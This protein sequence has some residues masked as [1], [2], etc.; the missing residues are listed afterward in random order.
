MA[1][2]AKTYDLIIIGAG[3]AGLGA[4]VYA[5]REGMTTLILEKGVVGGMAAI[6]DNIDNYPGFENGVGGLELADHLYD[7]AKRFGADIQ[8]GVEVTGLSRQD[9]NV[10]VST[11]TGPLKAR[12]VLVATGSTYK[13]LGVPGEA[14]QI[15]KGIHFCATCDGPLYRGKELVVVGGGNSAMQETLFLARFAS[16]ITMLVRGP[17]L[18]GTK[19]IKDQVLALPKLNVAYNTNVTAIKTVNNRLGIETDTRTTYVTDGLFIFIGLL[20]NTGMVKDSLELDAQNFIVTAPDYSTKMPGVYVAGDVRS[21]STWQIASAIGEGVT[22]TL[23]I[24]KYLDKLAHD[25]RHER[26]AA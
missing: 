19:V 10:V 13:H 8:T 11:S 9:G 14:E 16:K 6:T 18:K 22:A 23:E 2:G 26:T 12:S 5:A 21:G 1:S 25:Q 17:E 7:H 24:R 4:A 20:A 15:G 3:P